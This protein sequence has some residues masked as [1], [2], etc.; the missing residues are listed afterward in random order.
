LNSQPPRWSPTH[1]VASCW[2]ATEPWLATV[3]TYAEELG[4]AHRCLFV[5]K[6]RNVGYWLS[7]MDAL[8]LTS[9]FEGL[10]NV[11]IEAQLSGI[12]VISTP[13]GGAAEAFIPN[14][15]G[16][17]LGST[18]QPQ[19]AQFLGHFMTLANNSAQREVMGKAAAAFAAETFAMES[20]L[21]KTLH[22]LSGTSTV[23]TPHKS[24]VRA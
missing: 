19:L 13:A 2:S 11:L 10:P 9:R 14:Q 6:S 18:E 4:I 20:I 17:L 3:K 7:K 8:G 15:T 23:E 21:P 22:L 5:G 16:F 1:A 24:A 12:P